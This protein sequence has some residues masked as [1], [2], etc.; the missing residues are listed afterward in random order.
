ME[1]I[2]ADTCVE[3]DVEGN[4][5]MWLRREVEGDVAMWLRG[6]VEGDV[7]MWLRG[8]VEGD[9]AMWL[10]GAVEGD[11]AMWLRHHVGRLKYGTASRGWA[12]RTS[13]ENNGAD[14]K[15]PRGKKEK[16]FRESPKS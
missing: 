6:G 14:L 3:G 8:E 9:V 10:R 7:A 2:G 16:A 11:V 4:V 13:V 5:A 1:N 15:T 12:E